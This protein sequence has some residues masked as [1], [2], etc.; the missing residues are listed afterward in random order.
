[1]NVYVVDAINELSN[2][3]F[4]KAL[5]YVEVA[6]R[7]RIMKFH[8]MTDKKRS[9]MGTLLSGYAISKALGIAPG[10]VEYGKNE[11]GKP[12]VVSSNEHGESF[13]MGEPDVQFNIS[14][15]GNYVALAIGNDPV[16]IDVQEHKDGMDNIAER[17][18]SKEEKE[19]LAAA[20]AVGG[21]KTG[22]PIGE[23][24][25]S[26]GGEKTGG[27]VG[28][29][30]SGS[31]DE[32]TDLRRELFYEMWSLKEAYIKAIGKGLSQPLDEFG[33]INKNGEYK[34]FIKGKES[35]DYHFAKYDLEGYS[36]CV[37]STDSDFPKD[38]V[39]V[40]CKEILDYYERFKNDM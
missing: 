40:P 15:S 11:Y 10:E 26:S 1:M 9:L 30:A 3:A 31:G 23:K 6:R 5:G 21:E 2:E 7:E 37:C 22:G 18:F 16:G 33:V 4:E 20:G 32:T 24:T 34:L 25:G 36:L 12:F 17:F 27:P 35:T 13:A 38:Y 14:H 28:D 39:K 8:F 19:A 29:K